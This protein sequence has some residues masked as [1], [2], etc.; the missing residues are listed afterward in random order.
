MVV[1]LGHDLIQYILIRDGNRS[2]GGRFVDRYGD[3]RGAGS[4]RHDSVLRVRGG[5]E[6]D[7]AAGGKQAVSVA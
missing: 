6:S 1:E 2:K 4:D 5:E 3:L 7:A